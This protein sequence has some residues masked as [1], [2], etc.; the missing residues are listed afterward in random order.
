MPSPAVTSPFVPASLSAT[1]LARLMAVRSAVTVRPV[2]AGLEP[3]VTGT[4]NSSVPLAPV[5]SGETEPSPCGLVLA[6]EASTEPATLKG[7]SLWP[8]AAPPLPLTG[9]Q[10]LAATLNWTALSVVGRLGVTV[11]AKGPLATVPLRPTTTQ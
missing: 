2:L 11:T 5:T 3:G 7:K 1:L 9:T 4:V 6:V 8:L 10:A